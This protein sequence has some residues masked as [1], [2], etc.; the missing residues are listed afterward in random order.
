MISQ[1]KTAT[2]E[3][4]RHKSDAAFRYHAVAAKIA[5]VFPSMHQPST[6]GGA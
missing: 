3:K 2:V 5:G 4:I 6:I 1:I